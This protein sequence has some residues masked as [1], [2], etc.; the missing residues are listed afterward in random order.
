MTPVSESLMTPNNSLGQRA[1]AASTR[2]LDELEALTADFAVHLIN[3]V[4]GARRVSPHHLALAVPGLCHAH[5][6]DGRAAVPGC[7]Y[8][9]RRGNCFAEG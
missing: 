6:P 4:A 9:A 5:L 7:A 1:A 8:C 2:V 3:R